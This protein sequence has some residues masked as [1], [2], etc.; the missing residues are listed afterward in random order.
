MNSTK[1]YA[2]KVIDNLR[3]FIIEIVTYVLH[4]LSDF[5]KIP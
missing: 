3:E 4:L 2:K 5:G 1:I